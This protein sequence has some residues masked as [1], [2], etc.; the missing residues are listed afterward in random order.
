MPTTRRGFI[1]EL[2][3]SLAT[4]G[5]AA[6]ALAQVRSGGSEKLLVRSPHHP[7]P[8]PLGYDRL[9]LEWYKAA[10][11]RL[12][13]KAAALGVDA[14]LLGTDHNLVY[15]TGCFRH[16]GERSTWALFPVSEKDTVY[17]YSPGIDR[18]LIQSW[19]CTE[20]EYYF[21]YPH[22]EGGFPNKG[23]LGRGKRVDPW[24]WLLLGLKKRGL[25][26]KTIGIEGELVPS[27]AA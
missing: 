5:A 1:H 11:G 9:P 16:S 23:Q 22:A 25:G 27:R 26:E 14:V 12:K 15:F 8:A 10:A 19:W 21:C 17:W 3:V 18:D 4:A 20:N 2:G 24:E 13:E 6:E 7:E